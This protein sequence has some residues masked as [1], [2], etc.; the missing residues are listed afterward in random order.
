MNSQ[1]TTWQEVNHRLDI[2]LNDDPFKVEAGMEAAPTYPDRQ[3]L[4]A[5]HDAQRILAW[6]TPRQRKTTLVIDGDTRSAILPADLLDVY[7]IYDSVEQ[8]WMLKNQ[9]QK[10]GG[11]RY[12]DDDLDSFWIWGKTLWLDKSVS[13]G[14]QDLTLYYWAYWPEMEYTLDESDGSVTILTNDILVPPW[15][16]LPLCHLTAASCM[17]PGSI[18]A[19]EIRNWNIKTDSG[20]PLHN[21][22]ATEAREHLW[23]WNTLIG[24][25][26]RPEG[27]L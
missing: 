14:S 5:W 21:V 24:S 8:K 12:D 20:T 26:P 17:Q 11:I 7:R 23:W 1:T 9:Y 15:A 13:V 6:H 16:I 25:V 18:Q 4:L 19:A 3:R 2:F 10:A 27:W 22:R